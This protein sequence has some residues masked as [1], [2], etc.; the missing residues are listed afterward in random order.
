MKINRIVNFLIKYQYQTLF[1]TWAIGL[2]LKILLWYME[3]SVGRDGA[4]YL[5]MVQDWYDSGVPPIGWIPPMLFCLMRG[6][7]FFGGDV[8][9]AGLIVNIGLG[10]FLTFVAWGIA[11]EATRNKKIALAAAVLGALHP[12]FT[13][14]SVE[15]QRDVP[16]LFFAG[17]S[18]WFAIAALQREK[19]FLWCGSGVFLAAATLTRYESVELIP[20]Y[21]IAI[22]VFILACRLSWWQGLGHGCCFLALFAL[23]VWGFFYFYGNGKMA[24]QYQ[25]YFNGQINA[26]TQRQFAEFFM[27]EAK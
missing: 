2:G 6:I 12:S 5:Q 24:K 26:V 3:P 14:L 22:F 23:C 9:T 7:M 21:F 16:Y 8:E 10:S 1:M 17:V 11:Y 27:K 15:V 13:A 19:W 18:I 4:L 20:L 25:K